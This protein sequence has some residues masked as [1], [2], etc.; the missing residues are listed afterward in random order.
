MVLFQLCSST[1]CF[2]IVFKGRDLTMGKVCVES[3]QRTSKMRSTCVYLP[4]LF[5]RLSESR[6]FDFSKWERF[7]QVHEIML[8]WPNPLLILQ[9]SRQRFR[10]PEMRQCLANSI[11]EFVKWRFPIVFLLTRFLPL[12]G[13]ENSHQ[14][15]QNV[16]VC[17]GIYLLPQ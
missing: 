9:G 5:H 3:S 17:L 6:K 15:H 13:L 2:S 7:E 16:T 10:A 8:S 11:H 14:K 4:S 12:E 1:R